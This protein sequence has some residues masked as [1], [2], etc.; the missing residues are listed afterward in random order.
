LGSRPVLYM[1]VIGASVYYRHIS[2]LF[3]DIVVFVN[4]E[5][6][7]FICLFNYFFVCLRVELFY[8]FMK[9]HPGHQYYKTTIL[10]GQIPPI[11][12]CNFHLLV[13]KICLAS[14]NERMMNVIVFSSH[15][16]AFFFLLQVAGSNNSYKPITN[17]AWVRAR[18]CICL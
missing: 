9:N 15:R 2:K 11:T 12:S 8:L 4:K 10:W 5:L 6:N 3:I 13:T 1:F 16:F 7:Y 14:S 17:T 18:F